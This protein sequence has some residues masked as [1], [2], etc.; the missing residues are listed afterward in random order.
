M[1]IRNIDEVLA[2]AIALRE[3]IEGHT[4]EIGLIDDDSTRHVLAT[5]HAIIRNM[6][7]ML[8][9]LAE[10]MGAQVAKIPEGL[11]EFC[12]RCGAPLDL[13][14]PAMNALSRVDNKTYICSP[15]GQK[16]AMF[17]YAHPGENLP[18]IDEQV[19]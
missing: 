15:C 1:E 5:H 14:R 2:L 4:Q 17:N 12:P 7:T 11:G 19:R 16:E 9:V 8:G 3:I 13:E 6:T 10:S 18:P